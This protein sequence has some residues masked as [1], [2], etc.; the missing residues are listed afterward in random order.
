MY[1]LDNIPFNNR[2]SRLSSELY[3]P[4]KPQGLTQPFLVSANPAVADLIGLDPETLKTDSFIEYFSGNTAL[5]NAHPLAMVYSGHQFGSYNPQLGDG[6]GLLL[7]E[8]E[9]TSKGTWDLH[10]KGAG[11]TPYSRFADGRAVLRSTIREYLCS[12]AMAGLGIATTRGLCIIGSKTPVYR[13]TPEMGATL[14]RVAQSHIRFGSFEYF[15]YNNRPD[16]V[17]QLADYVITRNYPDLQHSKTKYADFLLAVVARTASM[18]AQWQAVGFA[19]G[20]MNTDNMSIVG[21]TFDFGPF[22]FLDDY[23]PN[24]ICNHSDHQ[25]R[26]A[27]N[28]QPGIGLWN[29]NALAHAL[30][31]L[32][33]RDSITNA[34]SQYER[35][36]V[37]QYNQIF[38]AKLGLLQERDEDTELA[39][40]LLHLLE[41]Q[42]ADYTNFFRLLSHCNHDRSEIDTML[43]DRFVDRQSFDTWMRQYQQRLIAENSDSELRRQTMLNANPKYILRNYIAQ[44]AIDKATK[45]QDYSDIDNL[46]TILQ[47]PF[48]EHPLFSEYASEPPDWGKRLEISCSS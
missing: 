15:H 18:I 10:L 9:T 11:Q 36:L 21:D 44:Q 19:H 34:L 22:G 42:K 23:D 33:D 39:G 17:K 13:E 43:R 45:D 46:L 35:L 12:E 28:Q 37:E 16:I 31:T 6:R 5:P 26:Y 3:S 47:S 27:F 25:G 41:Q 14:V 38:R 20:V 8:V 30:S 24:F 1:K 48:E 2:F 40:S 7:G 32:I 29:L 4:V